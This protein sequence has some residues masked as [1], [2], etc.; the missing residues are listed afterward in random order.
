MITVAGSIIADFFVR[1]LRDEPLRGSLTMVDELGFHLGG[2][3][4]NTGAV[5]ARLGVPVSVVGRI[6]DDPLGV[7]VRQQLELWAAD[8]ILTVDKEKPTTSVVGHV[9]ENGERSFLSIQPVHAIVFAR[10]ISTSTRPGGDG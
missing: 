4:A 2:A 8:V 7:L 1:T 10:R 3:A 6:G 9:F 5:L